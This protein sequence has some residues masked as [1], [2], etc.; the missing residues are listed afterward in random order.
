MA[1]KKY[2]IANICPKCSRE[3]DDTWKVCLQCRS[4]L[5]KK[6]VEKIEVAEVVIDPGKEPPGI[7]LRFEDTSKKIKETKCTCAACGNIWYYGKEELRRN[8][9][10]R[11]KNS[12]REMSNLSNNML[13]CGGCLPALFMPDKHIIPVKDLNKCPKCNSSAIK[14]EE[15]IHEIT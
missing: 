12:G 1:D 14:K 7:K 4:P 3:Y 13:C 8:K 5:I 10:E 9:S 11:I 15:I 2:Y 6:Q